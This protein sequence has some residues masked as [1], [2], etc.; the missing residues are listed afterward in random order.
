MTRTI[1]YKELRE[2]IEKQNRYHEEEL[3][4]ENLSIRVGALILESFGCLGKRGKAKN[5]ML[6][7][8]NDNQMSTFD[9]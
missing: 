2:E 5:E 8:E 4:S 1:K 7:F 6:A 3:R 9:L